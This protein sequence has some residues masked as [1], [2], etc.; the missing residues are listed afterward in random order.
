M[1]S[2]RTFKTKDVILLA[3]LL[4]VAIISFFI[5]HSKPNENLEAVIVKDNQTY[6]IINLNEV[7]QPYQINIDGSIPVIISVEKNSI[8][9]KNSECP[10]KIC[11]NTG[12]LSKAGDIAVCLPA[13]VSIELRGNQKEF[14]SITG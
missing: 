6:K 5:I 1:R 13:K 12:R 9:F 8:Y 14:D 2:K 10:D 7:E 3:T 11:V 4:I